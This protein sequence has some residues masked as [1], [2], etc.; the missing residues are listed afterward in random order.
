MQ[1]NYTHNNDGSGYA[2]SDNGD[3]APE[4]ALYARHANNIIRYNISENNRRKVNDL[5]QNLTQ[6][7]FCAWSGAGADLGWQNL[8]VY[9]NTFYNN[10]APAAI[11]PSILLAFTGPSKNARFYNNIFMTADGQPQIMIDNPQQKIDELIFSHNNYWGTDGI[12]KIVWGDLKNFKDS[13]TY[14]DLTTWSTETG[15]ERLN[16]RFIGLNSDPMLCNPGHG[17]T[18]YPNLLTSLHAYKLRSGSPLIDKGMVIPNSGDRDFYGNP[19]PF[20]TH[21]DIG[22]NEFQVSQTCQ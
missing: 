8:L 11:T 12:F 10:L 20:N 1:Y 5:K 2:L 4:Y 9:N 15:Q 7:S 14:N 16:D 18:I 22:A 17:G 3:S 19:I 21:Y 13:K 6:G